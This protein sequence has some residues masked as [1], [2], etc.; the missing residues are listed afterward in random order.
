MSLFDSGMAEQ[1]WSAHF[2]FAGVRASEWRE[3]ETYFKKIARETAELLSLYG[4]V[5][6]RLGTGGGKTIIAILAAVALGYR[7]L[8]LTPTRYLTGQHKKLLDGTLGCSLSSRVIT[9]ETSS[10]KRIWNNQ[11]E[12]FVFATGAVFYSALSSEEVSPSEFDLVVFDEFHRATGQMNTGIERLVSPWIPSPPK[13]DEYYFIHLTSE[14][15]RADKFGWEVLGDKLINDL[16]GAGLHIPEQWH[17]SAG[18]LEA[19]NRQVKALPRSQNTKLLRR[20]YAKYRLYLYGH[21]VFMTGSY[22]SF[23]T[24][25]KKLA[26]RKWL[27]DRMLLGE[28]I[29]RRLIATAE[30]YRDEH[31]KVKKLERLLLNLR[32]TRGRAIVFFADRGTAQYCRDYLEE[33][34]ILTETVFGGVGSIQRQKSVADSLNDGRITA[35]LATSVWHEGVDLPEVDL[36]LNYS[37]ASSGKIRIQS[38]GRTGRMHKGRMAHLMLDHPLDRNIFFAVHTQTKK[39]KELSARGSQ[40]SAMRKGQ[41]SLFVS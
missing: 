20:L 6:I 13:S 25:A 5:G 41:L 14:M 24:Y 31:P 23:L 32:R 12:R 7:T 18:A 39:I 3:K 34:C 38:G 16:M 26:K 28:P 30:Y 35:A 22:H 8:F 2:T 9:G 36:V 21:H 37:V 19:L 4:N 33:R 11:S 27:P 29:F 1:I 17:C 10:G 15:E 40:P